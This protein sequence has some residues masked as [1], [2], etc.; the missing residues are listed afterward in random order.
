M[1]GTMEMRTSKYFG[2]LCLIVLVLSYFAWP[3]QAAGVIGNEHPPLVQRETFARHLPV[4]DLTEME[5]PPGRTLVEDNLFADEENRDLTYYQPVGMKLYPYQVDLQY[6]DGSKTSNRAH[7]TCTVTSTAD[8]GTGTLRACLASL[9]AGDV[10]LFDPAVFPP[11]AP[12]TITLTSN[13]P[14]IL[15]NNVTVDA[16]NAG[17][18]L[19][20]SPI[21]GDSFGLVIWGSQGVTIRGVQIVNFTLGILIGNGAT[22][23]IIGGDR[24]IGSGPLGQGN[25]ISGNSYVGVWL[26]NAGTSHNTISG[27]F[28]GTNLSGDGA[29][30]NG[31]AGL[32]IV[33]GATQNVIGGSHGPGV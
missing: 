29:V 26:Q 33:G 15:Q 12:Q 4:S 2:W 22:N 3:G 8:S 27:N 30:G 13:L 20:G 7:S 17:V 23:N 10:I 25:R 9:A 5:I 24:A 21:S 18:I 6:F 16:S 19:D 28:I 11:A 14:R 32:V 31:Y 1:K